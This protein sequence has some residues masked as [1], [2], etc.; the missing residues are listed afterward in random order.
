M[1]YLRS[2]SSR[3]SLTNTDFS[4]ELSTPALEQCFLEACPLVEAENLR[5]REEREQFE[6]KIERKEREIREQRARKRREREASELEEASR[7]PQQQEAVT[8]P[9]CACHHEGEE[10][11][12]I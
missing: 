11:S 12:C 3:S 8:V 2:D 1:F 10:V 6:S 9:W 5:E 7:W 4:N